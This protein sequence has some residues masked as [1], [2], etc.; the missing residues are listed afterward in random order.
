[1]A[2]DRVVEV[3]E[4]E[5]ARLALLTR[6]GIGMPAAGLLYWIVV[7]V[8]VR[9]LPQP[10]ALL[11]MFFATGAVFP[12]GALLTRLAGGDL[13]ARSATLTSLGLILASVQLFYWPV[14]VLV[15]RV[16]PD[17][18]PWTMA[19]LFG[20]HFLPYL[21]LYRSR[22]YA[23]LAASSALVLTAGA[24][25]ARGPLYREAPVLAAACYA[26]AV[27]MLWREVRRDWA[28]VEAIA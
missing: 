24:L 3:F 11:A 10:T 20:S 5:R 2:T 7:A 18:T 21:W 15:Y 17:W 9:M 14:I 13:F 26:V 25:V 22:A 16:A 19:V 12:V 28:T 4:S 23:F 1:M 27:V 8:M 6:Q